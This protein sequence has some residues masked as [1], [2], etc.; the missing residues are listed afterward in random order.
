M[1]EI[2]SENEITEE[3]INELTEEEAFNLIYTTIS[4]LPPEKRTIYV[5]LLKKRFD[6]RTIQSQKYMLKKDMM[7][8]GYKFFNHPNKENFIM[9]VKRK[10]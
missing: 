9:G 8:C 6:F 7:L 1:K 5:D 10:N 4:P 2:T 3:N